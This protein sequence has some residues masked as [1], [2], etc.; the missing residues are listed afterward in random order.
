MI[1]EARIILYATILLLLFGTVMIFST[2][3]IYSF[4]HF[5]SSFHYLFRHLF[6]M[7]FG[8]VLAVYFMSISPERI[9]DFSRPALL[10][11][12][13]FLIAVLIPG[14]GAEL[15][16]ARRWIRFFGFGFQ[17]S[18][19]AK[20]VLIIYLADLTARKKYLMNSFKHTFLPAFS[21]ISLMAILI[22]AQPDMGSSVAVFFIGLVMLFIGGANL[23][24]ILY[25]A[26]L[27]LPPMWLAIWL[28]PYRFRR[29]LIFF[30]PWSDPRGA[31]FQL[32]QSFIA[33]GSGGFAGVGLGGSRQKL[34][35]LPEA[36]TDFVFSIIGEELG[37]LG[38]MS[39]MVLFF[40]IIFCGIR[41][42]LKTKH[43]FASRAILGISVMI[44]FEAFV[45]IGVSVG[46]LPT[47]GLPL[48]FMSYGGSSLVSHLAVMGILFNLARK[49]E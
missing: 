4:T 7:G 38:A 35:Y 1:K 2:S 31:G 37:F 25:T 18:E 40:I 13:I 45:N 6:F 14:I 22:L 28:E 15:G 10:I 12:F 46:G 27:L 30:D 49:A 19:L 11:V 23:K 48:P 20:F 8:I 17:P 21:V 44:A 47:K 43:L 34:F 42:A 26:F 24:Y 3:A 5:G 32:I 36:H 9:A 29:I 41:I 33:L 39:V 16:G